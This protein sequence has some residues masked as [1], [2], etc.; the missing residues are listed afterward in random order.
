MH[1]ETEGGGRNTKMLDS[2]VRLLRED[3]YN[4]DTSLREMR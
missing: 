1:K 4:V 3:G 2:C